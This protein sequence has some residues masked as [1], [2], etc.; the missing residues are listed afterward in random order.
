MVFL[1]EQDLSRLAAEYQMEYTVFI[2]MWC[3]WVA[4]DQNSERLSLKEKSNYDC[5][6]WKDGCTVY[7]A[8]PLQC[9]SFPF[10]DS[11]VCSSHAWQ[12]AGNECPGIGAGT[13]HSGNTIAALLRQREAEPPI[14]RKAISI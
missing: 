14:E 11:L 13:L 9:R 8:R 3:R 6:F 5:I 7:Q 4:F 2:Q 12:R 1:S 10:W